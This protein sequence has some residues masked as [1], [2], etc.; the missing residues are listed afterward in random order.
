MDKTG[1]KPIQ[2]MGF[3]LMTIAFGLIAFVPAATSTVAPFVLLYGMSYLFSEF[4]PNSTTF[5]YPAEIFPV[6]VRTTGHGLSAAAGKVG[7]FV[8]S[9]L[10]PVI[11]ASS[12]GLRGAHGRSKIMI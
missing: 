7:A 12:L 1:R 8:G 11:L 9:Y 6:E 5:V 10:F 2:V 4:G 3:G